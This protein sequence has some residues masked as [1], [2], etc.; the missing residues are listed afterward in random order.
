MR[1]AVA[2]VMLLT[3]CSVPAPEPT[4]DLR[5]TVEALVNQRLAEK[6]QQALIDVAVQRQLESIRA[7]PTPTLSPT[8]TR[9]IPTPVPT[10]TPTPTPTPTPTA[11]PRPSPTPDLRGLNWI[12]RELV[13]TGQLPLIP[14][15]LFP[16]N[17]GQTLVFKTQLGDRVAQGQK[18]RLVGIPDWCTLKPT[19]RLKLMEY[20]VWLGNNIYDW[21]DEQYS[22]RAVWDRCPPAAS[23]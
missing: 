15:W 23:Y 3:A 6:E 11:T 8:A 4:P 17:T 2:M 22:I 19:Q 12:D 5:P 1:W 14:E 7:T 16:P 13:T 9:I 21:L 18:I 20:A 10:G